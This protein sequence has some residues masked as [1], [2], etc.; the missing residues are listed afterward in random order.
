VQSPVPTVERIYSG[1][2]AAILVRQ[3]DAAISRGMARIEINKGKSGIKNRTAI[4]KKAKRA[5]L[6]RVAAK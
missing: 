2:D 6:R 4:A 5:T 3:R 1:R